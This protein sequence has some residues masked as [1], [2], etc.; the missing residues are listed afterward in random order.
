ME[1]MD[2][3]TRIQVPR[4]KEENGFYTTPERSK[5]MSK[6]KSKN[7]KPEI[8]LRKKLWNLG[9][10]YRLHNKRLPG[11]PDIILEKFK[12]VIFV[13]GEFWHGYNWHEKKLKI[14]TNREFWI[15]KIERNMERDIEND[16]KIRTLGYKVFRFWEHS[17]KKDIDLCVNVV[18][19]YIDELGN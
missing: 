1:K 15:P 13:D 9:F 14:K 19:E 2:K 5:L 11:N 16:L 6:I 18:Q 4:F 12:I 17:I 3:K 7:T 10:R 8:K